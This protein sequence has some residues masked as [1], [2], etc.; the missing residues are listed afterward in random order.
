[1]GNR[2]CITQ[3]LIY[4]PLQVPENEDDESPANLRSSQ[5]EKLV[6]SSPPPSFRSRASSPTSRRLLTS[7]DPLASDAERT[8][9]DAFDDGEGSDDEG[10]DQEDDRQGLMRRTEPQPNTDE[11]VQSSSRPHTVERRVTAFPS[12]T[13][14]PATTAST[15]RVYGGGSGSVNDGVFANLNA[16]PERGE[17]LE[18]E[19]PPVPCLSLCLRL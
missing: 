15:R 1:M 17:K 6:P 18:E 8:L 11:T 19:K 10:R 14:S 2:R 5:T 13:R 9:A 7:Q 4:I 16:K 3:R 12:F